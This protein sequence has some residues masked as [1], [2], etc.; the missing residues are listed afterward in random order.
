MRDHPTAGTATACNP[1][2]P[3]RRLS[4]MRVTVLA[5]LIAV[6]LT[7]CA[8]AT[9][10]P[11]DRSGV[12][13]T[14]APTTSAPNGPTTPGPTATGPNTTPG[15]E[16]DMLEPPSRPGNVT[17]SS[18]LFATLPSR[19]P[20]ALMTLTGT[21]E[22]GVESGCLLLGGYLLI[23]GDRDVL[24]GG[25]PVAVTGRPNPDLRSTCQQGIPFQVESVAPGAA[26]GSAGG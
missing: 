19:T 10:V 18:G 6:V 14:V 25:R 12:T 11:G 4:G 26:G 8:S 3:G 9:P 2:G 5:G 22:A 24:T 17:G 20:S 1:I 15:T 13:S 16:S 7:G 21:P 23:G